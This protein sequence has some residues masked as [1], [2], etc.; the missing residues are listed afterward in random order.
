MCLAV[1]VVAA[2]LVGGRGSAMAMVEEAATAA[3]EEADDGLDI[4]P[5][6]SE[7]RIYESTGKQALT[8]ATT[9]VLTIDA[10]NSLSIP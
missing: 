9:G 7:T 1:V 6:N 5:R 2:M 3:A 8:L 4:A 10:L